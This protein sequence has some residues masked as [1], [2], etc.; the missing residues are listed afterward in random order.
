MSERRL[1]RKRLYQL[2]PRPLDEVA[3]W[4]GEFERFFEARLDALAAHLDRKH[5]RKR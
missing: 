5:G 3:A 1:G 4:M 2:Q